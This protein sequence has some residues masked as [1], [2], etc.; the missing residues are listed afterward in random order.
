[1]A[2]KRVD[3]RALPAN[4]L[5]TWRSQ[6]PLYAGRSLGP[7][8]IDSEDDRHEVL[9][10]D[11][12]VIATLP[13]FEEAYA[14]MVFANKQWERDRVPMVYFVGSELRVGKFMKVGTTINV[15][16]RLKQLQA[17]SPVVL[18][19]FATI[20]GGS[21]LEGAYH[22]RWQRFRAHGEWFRLTAGMIAEITRLQSNGPQTEHGGV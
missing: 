17:Y 15:P 16:K 18:R 20:E 7:F 19:V 10:S 12:V 8:V 4:Q 3:G 1:M 21:E 13:T 5:S 22:L 6:Q 14:V 11:D 9:R 2:K